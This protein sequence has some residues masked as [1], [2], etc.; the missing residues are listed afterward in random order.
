[1]TRDF[2]NQRREDPQSDSRSS[3]SRR[4][5][6]ERTSRPARPRLNRDMVDRAW[7]NGA[8]Q[9]HPDY[10][11]R[12]DS[13]TPLNRDPRRPAQQTNRHSAQTNSNGRK[14][15]ANRQDNYRPGERSPQ[16]NNGSRPRTFG[17]SMR[18]FDNQQYD[19]Y[20]RRGYSKQPYQDQH[21]P[22]NSSNTQRPHSQSRYQERDQYRGTQRPDFDRDTSS[23]RSYDRDQER[24]SRG[25][26]RDTR[27]AR[28]YDRDQERPS[29]NPSGSNVKNPRWQSRPEK[30]H[31]MYSNRSPENP[32]FEAKHE[33][34]EGDYE[35]FDRSSSGR[36]H[37]Q[38]PHL[39][40][41]RN[42]T[43][44]PDG[45]VLKGSPEE[46]HKKAEFWTEIA[47]ESDELVKQ[48]ETEATSTDSS[49][50]PTGASTRRNTNPRTRQVS[51]SKQERKTSKASGR[52]SPPKARS[53]GPKPS[54]RGFKWPT[55]EEY[56]G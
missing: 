24:P 15:Y 53:T 20:E 17:S 19:Q 43:H 21:S 28:G 41:E 25:Y 7:E 56:P 4:Y 26:N 11:T 35:H 39:P 30:R 16:S 10:R 5:G 13:K 14:P 51:E 49:D 34:Y 33:L 12:S 42:V 23:P 38:A 3:S 9:N 8:R 18:K 50:L 55:P 45:R 40:E 37:T 48:V 36:P 52:K 32:R 1:M 29:R 22:G 46:Q 44:L 54:Q 27:S 31:D 6:E 47:Q 2:N